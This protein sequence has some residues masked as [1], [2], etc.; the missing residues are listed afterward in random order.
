V[1]GQR[2]RVNPKD[3]IPQQTKRQLSG[4]VVKKLAANMKRV[5]YDESQP[6]SG[7]RRWECIEM[8][9]PYKAVF[10]LPPET[11]KRLGDVGW[12]FFS[13]QRL[14]WKL[15]HALANE[16]HLHKGNPWLGMEVYEGE[17]LKLTATADARGIEHVYVQMWARSREDIERAVAQEQVEVFTPSN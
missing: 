9:S 13:S 1:G 16:L 11:E 17:G 8:T 4:S 3:L 14:P 10:L 2:L 5:G 6:I 12:E 7:V 15:L